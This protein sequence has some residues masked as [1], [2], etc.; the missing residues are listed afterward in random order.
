MT[1]YDFTS[2]NR[3]TQITTARNGFLA[4]IRE[5]PFHRILL[6]RIDYFFAELHY[7]KRK[8]IVSRIVPFVDRGLLSAYVNVYLN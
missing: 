3:V 8:N 1:I 7:D 6:Y 4:G 5:D 2:L